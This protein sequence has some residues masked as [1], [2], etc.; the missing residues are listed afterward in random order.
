MDLP[1][2]GKMLVIVGGGIAAV[3]CIIWL[4]GKLGL[5]MGNLPGDI[6][7]E[8]PGFSLNIPVMTCLILSIILTVI[9]NLFFWFTRK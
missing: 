3:G 6:Q 2:V 4:V 8:R 9:A 5:P 1:H 7:I